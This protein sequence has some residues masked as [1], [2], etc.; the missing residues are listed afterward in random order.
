MPPLP[1]VKDEGAW[2]PKRAIFPSL[3]LGG[4]VVSMFHL[5]CPRLSVE[6]MTSQIQDLVN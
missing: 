4:G 3:I 1:Q 2:R 6:A 5:I